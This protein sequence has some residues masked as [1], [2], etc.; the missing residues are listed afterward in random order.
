MK[1]DRQGPSGYTYLKETWTTTDGG[2]TWSYAAPVNYADEAAYNAALNGIATP[3]AARGRPGTPYDN[4]HLGTNHFDGILGGLNANLWTEKTSPILLQGTF[5][6]MDNRKLSPSLAAG[7]IMSFNPVV[8]IDPWGNSTS[9]IGGAYRGKLGVAVDS[10]NKLS[11]GLMALY[12]DPNRQR[13]RPLQRRHI[14]RHPSCGRGMDGRGEHQSLPNDHHPL[15]T[16]ANV[17][18]QTV[19]SDET[20]RSYLSGQSPVDVISGGTY[21]RRTASETSQSISGQPWGIWHMASGGTYTGTP[22][23]S[24]ERRIGGVHPGGITKDPL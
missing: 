3:P 20:D 7:D 1:F 2:A 19:R 22:G 17:F 10:T 6:W 11:G 23:I 16:G 8:N 15:T 21:E 9:R 14:R 24:T 18:T 13:R 4:Y 5:D 12:Q